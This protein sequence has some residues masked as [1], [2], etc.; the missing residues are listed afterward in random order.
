MNTQQLLY[1]LKSHRD[2]IDALIQQDSGNSQLLDDWLAITGQIQALE[3]LIA[4]PETIPTL[5]QMP[6]GAPNVQ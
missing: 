6:P 4:G 5:S 3:Q 2:E 1:M